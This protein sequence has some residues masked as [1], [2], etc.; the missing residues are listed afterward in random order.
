M[1]TPTPFTLPTQPIS[2]TDLLAQGVTPRM[3]RTRL[4][5]GDLVQIRRGV[6]VGARNWPAD[7]A[8][9]HLFS[10]RAEQVIHPSAVISH[11]SAALALGLPTPGFAQWEDGPVS[12]TVP[13]RGYGLRTP[14]VVHHTGPL[15][16]NQVQRDQEG[17]LVTTPA[18]TAVDLA[19]TRPLPEAVV[20]L[21]SAARMICARMVS[22]V[23]RSDYSNPR[24]AGAALDLMEQAAATV[25]A[26]R[27][28]P[29]FALVN[30]A[31]ESV[32]ESLSAA[33]IHLAH[34]PAPRIQ[35]EIRTPV[36]KLYPDFL[37]DDQLLIG[38]VD[39]AVKYQDSNAYVLEKEREQVLRD[40]G[41]RFVR[42]LAKEIML[43][44]GV[45]VDR[46]ARSLAR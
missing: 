39:G 16:A 21:D 33:H 20:L 28:R 6:Y 10:A 23:R 26:T 22:Q 18:R 42:W 1:R 24:L 4:A 27:L 9:R 45:V 32:A 34:L 46:I 17:Y 13:G 38:E 25:R 3:L 12:L 15:L 29:A 41:Y 37:W 8:G 44:P 40:L 43:T 2:R 31:R 14:A 30:P 7:G 36:G 35:A 11:E 19:S 5:S